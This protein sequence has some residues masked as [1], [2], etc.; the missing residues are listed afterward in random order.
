MP[1]SHLKRL[2]FNPSGMWPGLQNLKKKKKK[3]GA[4]ESLKVDDNVVSV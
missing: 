1:V 3:W 4:I 2:C